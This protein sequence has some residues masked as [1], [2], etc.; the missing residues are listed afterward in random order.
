MKKIDAARQEVDMRSPAFCAVALAL[1]LSP[2][3]VAPG[4]TEEKFNLAYVS[5]SPASSV[6]YWVAKDAG[7]FKK[8]GLD[9][10][11][12]FINGSTR[13]IQSLIA[14]LLGSQSCECEGERLR[15]STVC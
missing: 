8:H 3:F 13:S 6:A 1:I 5:D 11:M 4:N 7:L 12:I 10:D 15:R 9:M 2:M 14:G